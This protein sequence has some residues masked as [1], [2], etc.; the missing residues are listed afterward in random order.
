MALL[1][2]FWFTG[3]FFSLFSSFLCVEVIWFAMPHLQPALFAV[4][5]FLLWVWLVFA[6]W[7]WNLPHVACT[8]LF[9]LVGL[10]ILLITI[11]LFRGQIELIWLL[12]ISVR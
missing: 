1:T 12:L 5:C 3:Q 9:A 2:F 10:L 6:F 4:R 8:V 11:I 7:L